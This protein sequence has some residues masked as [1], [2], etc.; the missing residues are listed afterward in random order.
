MLQKS[1]RC[2]WILALL[3]ILG[4]LYMRL[5]FLKEPGVMGDVITVSAWGK[6]I[7]EHG[8]TEGYRTGANYPPVNLAILGASV[9]LHDWLGGDTTLGNPSLNRAM[10]LP[11]ILADIW[12]CFLIFAV[13][14]CFLSVKNALFAA[15][16]YWVY[17]TI[18]LLSSYWGQTDGIYAALS[19]GSFVAAMFSAPF[20]SGVLLVF[21]ILAKPQALFLAPVIGVMLLRRRENVLPALVGIWVILVLTIAPFLA[22]GKMSDLSSMFFARD[23][24]GLMP[25]VSYYTFNFWWLILPKFS[26]TILN[27]RSVVGPV[28]FRTVGTLLT[29]ACYTPILW[30]L[31]KTIRHTADSK[32]VLMASL[33]AATLCSLA[34]FLFMTRMSPRYYF[35]FIVFA[36]PLLALERSGRFHITTLL[37]TFCL[38]LLVMMFAWDINTAGHGVYGLVL[39]IVNVFIAADLAAVWWQTVLKPDRSTMS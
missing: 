23:T 17:P 31:H 21:S 7:H 22:E 29:L 1:A 33:A 15:I 12:V 13:L 6:N 14:R 26:A 25:Y 27:T 19:F 28:T 34:F 4:G 20:L 9:R 38:N 10:R 35:P 32:K 11:T 30:R 36:T 3:V 37:I 18:W 2:V 24:R 5:V 16:L 8:W 39:S